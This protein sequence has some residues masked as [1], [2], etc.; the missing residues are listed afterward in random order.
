M[1]NSFEVLWKI[2]KQKN[3]TFEGEEILRCVQIFSLA[4]PTVIQSKIK[5]YGKRSL[6]S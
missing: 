4:F 3:G 5:T 2:Y 6:N 1:K